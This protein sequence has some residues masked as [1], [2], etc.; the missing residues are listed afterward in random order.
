MQLEAKRNL[1]SVIVQYNA[2]LLNSLEVRTE[3]LFHEADGEHSHI[4]VFSETWREEREAIWETKWGQAQYGSGSGGCR[5]CT[6]VGMLL[7]SQLKQ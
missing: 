3:R 1:K 4:I 7:Q 6:G 5:G 2:H